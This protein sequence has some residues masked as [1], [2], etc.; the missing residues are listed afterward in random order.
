MI[1]LDFTTANWADGAAF[2]AWT[3]SLGIRI[4]PL[5]NSWKRKLERWRAGAQANFYDID[6]VVTTL[7][8][9][10]SQ[11]PSEIW[12]PYNNGRRRGRDGRIVTPGPR[13]LAA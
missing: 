5:A 2:L 10:V 1:P 12:Q 4:I 9:H 7:G 3:D 11:V 13:A 8:L 6:A